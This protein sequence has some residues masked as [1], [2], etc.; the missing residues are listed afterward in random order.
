[1]SENVA[2]YPVSH[3]TCTVLGRRA[4]SAEDPIWAGLMFNGKEIVRTQSTIM[5]WACGDDAPYDL[6][7]DVPWD[8]PA[9]Q[10]AGIKS[11]CIYRVRPKM[12]AGRRWQG[13]TVRSVALERDETKSP[14]WVI[15]VEFAPS[16]KRAPPT[17]GD[18]PAAPSQDENPVA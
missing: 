8:H 3:E 12:E 16:R 10:A 11:E 7:L 1:M 5:R 2:V 4:K 13:R 14:P 15:R 9:D 6:H 18:A 17:G